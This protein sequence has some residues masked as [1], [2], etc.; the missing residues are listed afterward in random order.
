MTT[1]NVDKNGDNQTKADKKLDAILA[2]DKKDAAE[3]Q[4]A[5]ANPKVMASAT[6]MTQLEEAHGKVLALLQQH[7]ATLPPGVYDDL[8][9]L[10][11]I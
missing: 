5:Q 1:P 3:D 9:A 6:R 4:K 2:A 8:A 7:K 11:N 10:L